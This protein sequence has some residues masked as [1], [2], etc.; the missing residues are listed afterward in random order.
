MAGHGAPENH[1]L[2]LPSN[3]PP[4]IRHFTVTSSP[5]SNNPPRFMNHYDSST[6]NILPGIPP[7]FPQADLPSKL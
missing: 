7:P 5:S 3:I 6:V 1:F 2:M 4:S